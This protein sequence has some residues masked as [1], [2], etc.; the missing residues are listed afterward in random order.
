MVYTSSL[1][2][3]RALLMNRK[4]LQAPVALEVLEVPEVQQGLE[5]PVVP[6]GLEHLEVPEV[7]EALEGLAVLGSK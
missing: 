5:H 6:E 3:Y 7:P 2:L 4:V 1:V